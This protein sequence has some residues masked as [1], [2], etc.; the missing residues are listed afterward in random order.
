[1]NSPFDNGAASASRFLQSE[2][3]KRFDLAQDTRCDKRANAYQ[4]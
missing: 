4:L 3:L 2:I 1:M